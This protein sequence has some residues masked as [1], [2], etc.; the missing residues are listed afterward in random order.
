MFIMFQR[1]ILKCYIYGSCNTTSSMGFKIREGR[2]AWEAQ[3][4]ERWTLR[5]GSGHD[6]T[7]G[8]IKALAGLQAVSEESCLGFS[9]FLLLCPSTVHTLTLSLSLSK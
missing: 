6:L 3:S 2:G 4:V 9:L 1:Y 5:V 7:V 8:D